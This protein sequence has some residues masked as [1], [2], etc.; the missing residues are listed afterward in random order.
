MNGPAIQNLTARPRRWPSGKQINE[1]IIACLCDHFA[2]SL[3]DAL[4]EQLIPCLDDDLAAVLVYLMDVRGPGLVGNRRRLWLD[5]VQRRCSVWADEEIREMAADLAD[6]WRSTIRKEVA[7]CKYDGQHSLVRWVWRA[8][9]PPAPIAP[10]N[11]TAPSPSD[12]GGFFVGGM[13]SNCAEFIGQVWMLEQQPCQA[14]RRTASGKA[15]LFPVA[16]C[17]QWR[18]NALGKFSLAQAQLGTGLAQQN[19]LRC[20]NACIAACALLHFG[21][22]LANVWQCLACVGLDGRGHGFNVKVAAHVLALSLLVNLRGAHVGVFSLDIDGKEFNAAFIEPV[23]INHPSAA[24]LASPQCLPA[25]LA[26]TCRAWDHV[27]SHGMGRYPVNEGFALGIRPNGLSLTLECGVFDDGKHRDIVRDT[28]IS[29][30]LGT[31]TK[32]R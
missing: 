2:R 30:R 17:G 32:A 20:G 23:E 1:H 7:H 25:Y 19:L 24:T 27:A 28:R 4:R 21:Q 6:M 18:G 13:A 12:W 9:P 16:Q 10:K 3:H 14:Q 26:G 8:K 31:N 29:S 11:K 5:E 22:G 15:P